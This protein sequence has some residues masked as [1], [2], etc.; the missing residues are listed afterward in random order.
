M[1]CEEWNRYRIFKKFYICRYNEDAN[2][3]Y[4]YKQ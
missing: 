2:F 1:V 4:R 3:F